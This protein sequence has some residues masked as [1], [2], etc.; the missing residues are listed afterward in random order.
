MDTKRKG[1]RA[2]RKAKRILEKAGYLVIRSA[3]SLGYFDLV[4]LG[5]WGSVRLIQVK[6]DKQITKEERETLGLLAKEFKNFSVECWFFP[7]RS[8]EPVITVF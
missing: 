3:A 2:E 4:A 8:R 1:I 7:K 5:K 6:K